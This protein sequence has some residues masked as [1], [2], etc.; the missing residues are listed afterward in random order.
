MT[1]EYIK[2]IAM[3]STAYLK[4]MDL[5]K[6]KNYKQLSK[7]TKGKIITYHFRV[8]ESKVYF[9]LNGKYVNNIKCESGNTDINAEVV[10]C[11]LH[12]CNN[13]LEKKLDEILKNSKL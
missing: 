10:C 6:S 8:D 11:L 4:G 1:E 3:N 13:S 9:D 7:L 2:S 5:Y 12:I